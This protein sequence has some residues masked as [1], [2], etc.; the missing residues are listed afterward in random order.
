ME[1][2]GFER[3]M[4]EMN[5]EE[6]DRDRDA[7]GVR[8]LLRIELPFTEPH[9]GLSV[10]DPSTHHQYIL[11]VPPDMQTC[12]QAAAWVAGFDNPDDYQLL[13]ET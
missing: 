11:R 13:V 12:H 10:I 2:M 1:R 4:R 5:A 8:R 3:A 7:G 9:V 6:I